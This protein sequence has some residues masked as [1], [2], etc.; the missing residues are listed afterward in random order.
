LGTFPASTQCVLE[1][2]SRS[3]GQAPSLWEHHGSHGL[4]WALW[5]GTGRLW[6]GMAGIGCTLGCSP[7]CCWLLLGCCWAVARLLLARLA[8]G[9]SCMRGHEGGPGAVL[10]RSWR[11]GRDTRRDSLDQARIMRQN[12]HRGH[13]RIVRASRWLRGAA[14]RCVDSIF[15]LC[16]RITSQ[17]RDC[18]R[19]C[20]SDGRE[21]ER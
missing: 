6:L 8:S 15:T 17:S 3:P 16:V 12:G 11:L 10:G 13:A 19:C 5:S 4:P 14:R 2:A 1:K 21:R 18:C 9:G 20:T 7:G